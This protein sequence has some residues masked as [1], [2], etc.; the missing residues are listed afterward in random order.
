MWRGPQRLPGLD[1]EQRWIRFGKLVK[2]EEGNWK[3]GTIN[4][5]SVLDSEWAILVH[6]IH[7]ES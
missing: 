3:L 5:D 1:G 7:K 6:D 4:I 2:T